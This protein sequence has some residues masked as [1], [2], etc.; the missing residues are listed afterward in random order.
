MGQILVFDTTLRD[1]AKSPGTI[2][3]IEE[4]VRIA[5]QLARLQVDVLEAGFPAAS[6]EQNEVVERIA[7]NVTGPVIAVLARATNPR[8]FEIAWNAVKAAERAR[9]HTFVPASRAYREHFLKKSAAQVV[10]LGVAAVKMAKQYTPDVEFSLVDAFRADG[11]EVI[12]LVR[13][14]IGAGATTVNLADT[15]GI[16]LPSDIAQLFKRLREEAQDFDRTTFSVH[17]H[18]DLGLALANS[19]AAI[20]G[21]ATQVHCTINGIGERAGNTPLEELVAALSAHTSKLK[22]QTRIQ[23]DQLYPASRLVKRLTG[24]SL[25]PHKPVVGSN[26]FFYEAG[27]PQLADSTEKPPYEILRPEKLGIQASSDLLTAGTTVEQLSERLAEIGYELEGESLD[28]CYRAFEELASKKEHVFDA[29]LELLV[30]AQSALERLRYKLLYLNVTA[31]SISVPNATVQLDVD[32]QILQDAGFGH[33]PVDAAF[34]TI[35]KMAKRFPRLVRYEVN[36]ITTGTDAQGE[37]TIRLEEN[38]HLVDGRAVDTDIVLAS[39]KALVDGLNKLESVR[40]QT[41]ISEFTDEE[42]WMPRL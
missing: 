5:K 27:V 13:A 42:S 33:G 7:R 25:Q 30:G 28:A 20:E 6:E 4:E 12:Q 26:A 16:A 32:G 31:G 17:C 36:A 24:I 9:I 22:T 8:D 38:G 10:D 2:L 1:G 15:V 23:L 41:A 39:A 34:K 37:V 11:D 18:N 3:T 35:F 14:V 19:L 29:D 21:G 40:A